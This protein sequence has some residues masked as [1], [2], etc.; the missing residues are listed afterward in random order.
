MST[1]LLIVDVQH[2]FLPGGALAVATGDTVLG[3]LQSLASG[4]PI[5]VASRDFHPANHCSFVAEGG[6]WP[7]HCVAGTVGAE[8]HPTIAA[9]ALDV[10]VDKG[11]DPEREAYSAFDGTGLAAILRARG[12]THLLVGG[13]AT[14]YCV[15][16]SALDALREGF[17][18]TVV[19]DAVAAVD[20]AAGDGARALAEVAAAGATLRTSDEV[21]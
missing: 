14:D 15:R 5:V 21:G 17:A 7:S 2:D 9:L 11:T 4:T 10:V 1:A 19:T 18:V 16:A 20:V 12:V 13:L 6:V 8:L 3:P